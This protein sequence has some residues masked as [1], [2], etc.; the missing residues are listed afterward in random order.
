MHYICIS[1][2]K[3]IMRKIS[4]LIFLLII[5]HGEV[6]GL[7]SSDKKWGEQL[8]KP[9]PWFYGMGFGVNFVPD[10]FIM[11]SSGMLAYR[12]NK[13]TF[14]GL[15]PSFSFLLQRLEFYNP[16]LNKDDNY[17]YTS[18]YYESSLYLRKKLYRRI[19]FQLEP[20]VVNYK[21]LDNIYFNN[22]TNKIDEIS[23]RKT[24][25]FGLAGLGYLAPVGENSFFV[26]RFQYD[27]YGHKD[28]PYKGLP[29][30]RGGI[31]FSF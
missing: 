30:I 5:F 27:V 25:P 29:I 9:S 6:Y 28:S 2:S 1:L 10:G 14:I 3:K 22:S 26:I 7:G 11:N 4:I 23:K 20:G 13:K 31:N 24:V 12:I 8:E 16:I 15:N 17:V 19:F 21:D 18:T